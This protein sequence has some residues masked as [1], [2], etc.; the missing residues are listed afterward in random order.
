MPISVLPSNWI[1]DWRRFY[2]SLATNPAG[3]PLNLSRKIDP[4]VVP[5]LHTLPGG[6]GSLPFRNLK[7][8]VLLGL[9][10]GQDVAKAMKIK[11]PLT[12]AEIS[13]GTDGA[14]AKKHGL[15]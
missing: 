4:F 6:G 8:G 12:P 14:I 10:S 13:N 9:P 7:R 5:T 15:H 1:I 11:N 3:V 2:K